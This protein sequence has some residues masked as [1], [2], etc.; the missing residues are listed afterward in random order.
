MNGFKSWLLAGLVIFFSTQCWGL[1][2]GVGGYNPTPQAQKDSD[3]G[4][5][6]FSLDPYLSIS[7]SMPI[8]GTQLFMPELGY[9][10]QGAEAGEYSKRTVFFLLDFG[11]RLRPQ[12]LFRYGVGTLIT[13]IEGD[14][15]AVTR[16]NGT[17][18]STFYNP[19]TSASS[20]NTTLDLGFEGAINQKLAVR[21]QTYIFAFLSSES[22]TIGYTLSL[23]YFL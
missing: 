9:V 15:A 6:T 22:R 16:S 19:S 1:A 23:H 21:F 2:V 13:S 14:G 17:S 7:H 20:Y 4:K 12:F 5:R 18:T 8:I 3:G 10:F 11:W